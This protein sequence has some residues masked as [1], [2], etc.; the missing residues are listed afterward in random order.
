MT[1]YSWLKM[2][3]FLAVLLLSSPAPAE[4]DDAAP[5]Q[6]K[7]KVLTAKNNGGDIFAGK[8]DKMFV[9]IKKNEIRVVIDGTKS[10]QAAA[11]TVNP[12]QTPKQIEFTKETRDTEWEGF[13]GKVVTGFEHLPYKLFQSWKSN[14]KLEP[15]PAKDQVLGIYELKHDVLKLCWRTTAG[16]NADGKE[17]TIRPNRFKSHLYY[18]EILFELQR[19]K[20]A[21]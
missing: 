2:A 5:L 18:H 20:L 4:D 14:E 3:G 15:V 19:V 1:T 13:K 12:K 17:A 21:K 8:H 6:G 16:K 9:I 11:F 10:E 7:W